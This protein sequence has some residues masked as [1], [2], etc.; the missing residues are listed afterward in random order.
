MSVKIQPPPDPSP[1]PVTPGDYAV[2]RPAVAEESPAQAE[3][4]ARMKASRDLAKAAGINP[5]VLAETEKQE[6]RGKR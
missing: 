6:C 3:A 5:K 4:L 1:G 2:P